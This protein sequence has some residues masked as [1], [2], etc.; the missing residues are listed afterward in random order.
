MKANTVQSIVADHFAIK[1]V[2]PAVLTL[3]LFSPGA[4]SQIEEIVVTATKRETGLQETPIA[5]T[6]MNR[7]ELRKLGFADPSDLPSQTPNLQINSINGQSKPSVYLRGIGTN[8]FTTVAPSSVGFYVDEVYQGMQSAQLF[9]L[10]DLERIEVLRGPQGTLYGRNTTGGGINFNSIRPGDE[11]EGNFSATY[12][13]FDSWNVQG[14]VTM[15]LDD[16]LS[17]RISGIYRDQG[18]L[19]VNKFRGNTDENVRRFKTHAGRV[20][21]NFKPMDWQEWYLKIHGG[22][23]TGD[24]PRYHFKRVPAP[25][26]PGY[27]DVIL[28]PFLRSALG[29]TPF[30]YTEAG[31]DWHESSS[32]TAQ[33]EEIETFGASLIGNIDLNFATLTTITGYETVDAYTTFD[34]DGGPLAALIIV[35]DDK[36]SQFS[37]ELRLTSDIDGPFS[38]ILGAYY[39]E[40]DIDVDN[41]RVI[42]EFNPAPTLPPGHPAF[43]SRQLILRQPYTQ[44]SESYAVFGNVSYSF[45]DRASI[46][47]GVRYTEDKKELLFNTF[48]AQRAGLPFDIP[49]IRNAVRDE[50]WDDFTWSVVLDY[51]FSEDIYGYASYNR[52]FRSGGFNAA[53]NFREVDLTTVDPE[54]VDAFEVGL[55]TS[56]MDNRVT[57]NTAFFYNDFTDLQVFRFVTPPGA[58]P[59]SIP[60]GRLSNAG[61]A[62]SYGV[63]WELKTNLVEGLFINFAGSYLDASYDKFDAGPNP[64]DPLGPELDFAD[65]DL[66]SAPEWSLNG[67]VEYNIRPDNSLLLTPRFEFTYTGEQYFDPNNE[68][69]VFQG[70]YWLA[71]ASFTVSHQSFPL[72]VSVWSKNLFDEEYNGRILQLDT[73]GINAEVR[74]LPRTYGVTVGYVF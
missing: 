9:Q 33:D 28:P 1:L 16:T 34:G 20:G 65:N 42:N 32:S 51:A 29:V 5:I 69:D 59:G 17:I 11:A 56:M 30:P 49:L 45:I 22:K 21:I 64:F 73:F 50:S 43:F 61:S 54:N 72:Y 37:Q 7:E 40:E 10:Y 18:P 36:G 74:G 60:A 35:Q 24:G 41:T 2:T 3:M 25:S 55:K 6:A 62:T 14:G 66:T 12:G 67:T 26:G 71:N 52:G 68:A 13:N 39:Y 4:F 27:P 57:L 44:D 70:D 46:T 47:A 48:L 63:E 38:W 19:E 23:Y 53:A 31:N 15:P 58:P 8:D